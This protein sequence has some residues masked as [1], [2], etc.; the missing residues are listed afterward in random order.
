[1]RRVGK[2]FSRVE[3]PLFEGMIVAGVI[4]EEFDAEEQVQDV[5][6]DDAAQGADTAPQ[7]QPQP[8]AQQ[9]VADFPMS[10]LQE[11]LD[12]CAALARRVENLEY[13]KVA[14]ALEI[15]KLKRRV[16]KLEKGNMG[17]MINDLDKD[18]VVALVEDKEKENKEEE[19]KDNQVQGRQAEIYKIDLDHASK[20]LSIQED[21]PAEV[22]EVVDVVTTAKLIIEIVTAA[23]ETVTAAST[24]ISAAEPQVLAAATTTGSFAASTKRRK[25]VVIRDPEEESTT[26]I[27]ADT[28]FKDKGKGIM[29]E[30]P[31]PLKKKE[32]VKIDE[33]YAR[34]LHEELNKNIDCDVAIEHVHQKAK[35]DPAMQRYQV[36]KKRP[37][38]EA[39]ARKNMIMYL[40]NV[41]GFRLDYFKEMSYDDTLL[42]KLWEVSGRTHQIIKLVWVFL[43]LNQLIESVLFRFF[44]SAMADLLSALIV[45][46]YSSECVSLLSS[47]FNHNACVAATVAVMNSDSHDDS[48]TLACFCVLHLIGDSS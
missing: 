3:T 25:G 14:Q 35:E 44:I 21:K 32:Q 30:E 10:L 42:G 39:Q 5:V 48:A 20:V 41:A 26:I 43:S 13:D 22:Q 24:T 12:A 15:T 31:K 8:Q 40:K 23:S 27:P 33:E 7:P 34:K 36:M 28:K 2:G 47:I 11:A 6:D 17:R 4:K 37:Q 9:Q 46:L 16:K 29:V 45:T 38:T 19:V 18:D 1:M